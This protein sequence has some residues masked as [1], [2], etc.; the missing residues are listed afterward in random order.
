M[1]KPIKLSIDTT[2]ANGECL[3]ENIRKGDTLAMTI[4]IFQGSASLDL[5][6]QKMHIV[7]QKPDGYSVEKIVQSV[8]GNQFVVNFDVQATL[9]IGDVEGIVEISDSNGTN[10]TNTFTFEVKPNPSTNIVVKSSDQIETLQQ[11]QKLIDNYND[12]ADNLA[13]QN[14]LALQH[15]NTLT[16]LNNTSGT[17]ASR[18]ETDI[19][20]GTSVAERLED[21][22]T[23]GNALDVVLKADIANGTTLNNNLT[24]TISDG[25]N[26]IAQ[27]QNNANWQIIQQMFFLINKMSISNLEDENGDYLVD[28]NNLEFIG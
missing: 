13:L 14:Q 1:Q 2:N 5:T 4:K 24:I 11:I 26:V 12:N 15:E 10:I 28:E 9:G 3:Y 21:D 7:L 22:I 18:L 25:K 27:L 16:N 19:A 23:T 6:G 8:T 17:L 20:T